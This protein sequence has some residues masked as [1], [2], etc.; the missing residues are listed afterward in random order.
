M[1]AKAVQQVT[2][3][4]HN[5]NI[6]TWQMISDVI[7]CYRPDRTIQ[8]YITTQ[9]N[10]NSSYR[11]KQPFYH[12]LNDSSLQLTTKIIFPKFQSHTKRS[13]DNFKRKPKQARENNTIIHR[14]FLNIPFYLVPLISKSFKYWFWLYSSFV[15]ILYNVQCIRV[16]LYMLV[17]EFI[18]VSIFVRSS[19]TYNFNPTVS[20]ISNMENIR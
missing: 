5:G 7:K 14:V 1:A 2:V 11:Q 9:I 3:N 19:I 16:L 18:F 6:L 17:F 13:N 8:Y 20:N 15:I 10:T 12:Q 4:K